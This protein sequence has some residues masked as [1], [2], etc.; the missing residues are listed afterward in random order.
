MAP[1]YLRV[2]FKGKADF[3]ILDQVPPVSDR[4]W[5]G[6]SSQDLYVVSSKVNRLIKDALHNAREWAQDR[7][8]RG[9]PLTV[10]DIKK[11]L[12]VA[13]TTE[14]FNVFID[15]FIRDINKNKNDQEKLAFRTVQTY[16]SFEVRLNE[17]R[18]EINFDDLTP[19]LVANF[20][21]FLAVDCKLREVTRA[22][23]FDKFKIATEQHS[24]KGW[25][26]TM[27]SSFLMI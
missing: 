26:G 25:P 14:T 16:R 24:N 20:E 22:K 11:H 17:F 19:T 3:V 10:K 15:R 6:D 18:S 1:V 4:D 13:Q 12:K 23:H 8:L 21:R 7:I 5:I 9:D 27:K 2:Y